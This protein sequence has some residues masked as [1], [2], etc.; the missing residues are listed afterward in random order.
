MQP[1]P[2]LGTMPDGLQNQIAIGIPHNELMLLDIIKSSMVKLFFMKLNL[3]K[4]NRELDEVRST[5][6]SGGSKSGLMSESKRASRTE[7]EKIIKLCS[8]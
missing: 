4:L 2:M 6:S 5:S 8:I 3:K 1:F 7:L